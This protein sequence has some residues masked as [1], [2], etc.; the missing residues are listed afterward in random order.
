MENKKNISAKV[1]EK[2]EKEN[3][4]PRPRWQFLAKNNFLWASAGVFLLVGSLGFSVLFYILQYS[5]WD[6]F[7][8]VDGNLMGFFLEILPLFWLLFF[9][10]FLLAV[11]SNIHFT[12]KGYRYG[13]YKAILG[14]IS[15]SLF[16]GFIFYGLGLGKFL[17]ENL[18]GNLFYQNYFCPN[19]QIW[20]QPENGS[21]TGVV[22]AV[23]E[24]GAEKVFTMIDVESKT[25]QIFYSQA[26][27]EMGFELSSNSRVKILGQKIGENIFRAQEIRRAH[28]ECGFEQCSS[29]SGGKCNATNTCQMR[30][31]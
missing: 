7:Q 15:G 13:L 5:D 27:L 12:Q 10:V 19:A 29:C 18:R 24:G 14:I 28:C 25:W 22:V 17:E 8:R 30:I 20:N 26:I 9:A 23:E 31:E 3:V 2:I 21:L 1:W 16:L 11:F 6:L 4:K